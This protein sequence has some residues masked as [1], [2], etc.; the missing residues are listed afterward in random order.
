MCVASEAGPYLGWGECSWQDVGFGEPCLYAVE[1]SRQPG[2]ILLFVEPDA[3]DLEP[4]TE[5][6]L[7]C[8]MSMASTVSMQGCANLRVPMRVHQVG[9]VHFKIKAAMDSLNVVL[10][11]DR[12]R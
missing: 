8:C 9:R 4:G 3:M 5:S 11:R 6:E 2:E 12:I 10:C 1:Q 7:V